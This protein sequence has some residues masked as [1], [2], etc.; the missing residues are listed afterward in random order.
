[1]STEPEPAVTDRNWLHAGSVGRPHGLDGSFLVKDANPTLL[2]LGAIVTVGGSP[3]TIDRHAGHAARLIV[4]L[5]GCV[6]REQ[7]DALRGQA[8]LASR[9]QAPE[10][11]PDEWWAEDLEGC[12]VRDGERTVG[13][14]TRLLA[15]P[16]CEVLEVHPEGGGDAVLVPLVSDAVR[17]VDVKG[18]VIDV[19][20]SFLGL[21]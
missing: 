15:L 17:T 18:R 12:A 19:N 4:R 11:E 7:A 13:I 2:P 9:Q 6:S 1:L 21:E 5:E 3:R 8:L 16:S 10:L 20:L 14:V